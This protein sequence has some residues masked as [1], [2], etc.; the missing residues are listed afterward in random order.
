MGAIAL[1][2][3][4]SLDQRGLTGKDLCRDIATY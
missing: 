3:A 4:A 1:Q 2:D